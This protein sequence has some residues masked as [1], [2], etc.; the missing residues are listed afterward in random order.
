ME[1]NKMTKIQTKPPEI[2][3]AADIAGFLRFHG[4]QS[5]QSTFLKKLNVLQLKRAVREWQAQ[6]LVIRNHQDKIVAACVLW[7]AEKSG[8][9]QNFR[10][11]RIDLGAGKAA[12]IGSLMVSAD[13]Q[14]GGLAGQLIN[15]AKKICEGAGITQVFAKVNNQNTPSARSFLRQK[16][17]AV[18]RG[19]YP[20]KPRAAYAVYHKKIQ[21]ACEEIVIG[22]VG[23][24][25]APTPMAA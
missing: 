2:L 21:T 3:P 16:F 17:E 9:L 25:T 10:E 15:E 24:A 13:Y 19:H 23:G 4:E 12:I 6:I 5:A 7:K 1:I 8:H 14:G 20:H 18:A 11:Y 22:K